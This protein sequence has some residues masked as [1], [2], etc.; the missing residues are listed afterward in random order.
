M[1]VQASILLHLLLSDRPLIQSVHL[2]Y[3]AKAHIRR[4]SARIATSVQLVLSIDDL[5]PVD[6]LIF[7]LDA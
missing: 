2:A 5:I 7:D 1:L 4:D 6:L 3:S